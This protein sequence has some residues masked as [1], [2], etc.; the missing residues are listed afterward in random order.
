[1]AHIHRRSAFSK[2]AGRYRK[3]MMELITDESRTMMMDPSTMMPSLKSGGICG[4]RRSW[5][6][7]GKSVFSVKVVV[8]IL[9]V[10]LPVL[11]M[12]VPVLVP[13]VVVTATLSLHELHDS[14][15]M[16]SFYVRCDNDL[17]NYATM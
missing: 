15:V 16:A 12:M 14:T 17:R 9:V 3:A 1:M 8:P 10:V 4:E 11:V 2:K 13:M 7:G 5:R 6:G